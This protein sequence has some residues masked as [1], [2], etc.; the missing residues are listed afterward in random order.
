MAHTF[1]K[2]E[3]ASLRS[4]GVDE[5]W[6]QER[7]SEDPSILGLGDLT[8]LRREKKQITGGRID[9]L[10]S[11]PEEDI[12]YEV[13]VMLGRLDESHIIRSIEYWDVE[14][15]RNPD[16]EHR[17]VIVAEDITNRFFNVISL[18]NRAV[19]LIA[20][21]MTAVKFDDRFA[22]TFT[23]VLDVADLRA[24]EDETPDEQKDRPY[25]DARAGKLSL[26]TVD[27]LLALLPQGL[28]RRVAYNQGHIAVGTSGVN[29]LWAY[30]RKKESHCFFNLRLE[31]DERGAWIDKLAEA[32]VFA[33]PRGERM[34]MRVNQKEVRENAELLRGLLAVVE[35]ASRAA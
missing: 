26:G 30:P 25:W 24:P 23:K 2:V 11:D 32:G 22:L 8:V 13:E 7:I 16:A 18:L 4:L 1:V 35:G 12:R 31:G 29:F 28:P 20:I 21:Q 34:K 3:R 6:L 17:A 14:R 19:P 27:D 15:T 10:L 9:F 33:G 5:R